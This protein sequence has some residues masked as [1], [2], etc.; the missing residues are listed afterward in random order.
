VDVNTAIQGS[1]SSM[2]EVLGGA[3]TKLV[4]H[5]RKIERGFFLSLL[6]EVG[7]IQLRV[8]T[9]ESRSPERAKD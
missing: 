3:T 7:D 5:V 8:L 2:L 1:S 9:C 6:S 4:V